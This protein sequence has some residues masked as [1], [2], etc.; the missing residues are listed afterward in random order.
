[1]TLSGRARCCI[2]MCMQDPTTVR[3]TRGTRDGLR[4]LA[5]AGGVS[6]DEETARLVRTERQRRMGRALAQ[7]EPTAAERQWLDL[8]ATE[9]DAIR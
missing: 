1:M 8:A 5:A 2:L 3:V 4:A 9:A 6:L 7:H